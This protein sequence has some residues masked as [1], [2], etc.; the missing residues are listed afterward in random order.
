MF[1]H[2]RS[3]SEI[4]TSYDWWNKH[5]FLWQMTGDRC[6]YIEA[7]INHVFGKNALAQQEILEVGCGGGLI[8]EELAQ[9]K[10]VM[11]GIDPSHSALEAA[12]THTQQSG[13]G[14]NIYYQ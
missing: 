12:R 1:K 8:C 2:K 9:R 13:L 11:V 5:C 14:H 7:S 6:D 10:A 4:F 3:Q